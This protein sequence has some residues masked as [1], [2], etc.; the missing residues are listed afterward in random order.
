MGYS[1]GLGA[2]KGWH[3]LQFLVA[4]V[5]LEQLLR[6]SLHLVI[7]NRRVPRS[8]RESAIEE[9]CAAYEVYVEAMQ[10][11]RPLN[12]RVTGPVYVG[13]AHSLDIIGEKVID[14]TYKLMEPGEPITQLAPFEVYFSR[15]TVSTGVGGSPERSLGLEMTYPKV[16]FFERE[17]YEH[18]R[19]AATYPGFALLWELKAAIHA[20]SSPCRI[21]S[22]EKVH[23]TRIRLSPSMREVMASH[24][25][26]AAQGLRAL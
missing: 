5:E 8:Y 25:G 19:D 26:L 21:Q 6:R 18:P 7:T 24:P 22:A 10:G 16:V 1:G 11:V 2:G 14:A 15:G 4:S 13:L 9:Y 20:R 23:R 3:R 17:G 12:W